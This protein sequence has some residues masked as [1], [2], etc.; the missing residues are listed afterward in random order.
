MSS[1][2][3]LQRIR[4]RPFLPFVVVTTDGTRY[5]VRHPEMLMPGRRTVTIGLPDDPGT[6]VY[7]RQVIVSMLHVQ[8]LELTQ[9]QPP[10][11]G[12]GQ[13]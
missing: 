9:A 11:T 13:H 1:D 10:G 12:H 5:E 8:R 3:L 7:D 4:Q 2:D 6:P